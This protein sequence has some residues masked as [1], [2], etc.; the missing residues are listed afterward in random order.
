MIEQGKKLG[1]LDKDAVV[2]KVNP[3]TYKKA[4]GASIEKKYA[5]AGF[6]IANPDK[7]TLPNLDVAV[8]SGTLKTRIKETGQEGLIGIVYRNGKQEA[9]EIISPEL[10]EAFV[11]FGSR[12]PNAFDGAGTNPG[13]FFFKALNWTSRFSSRAITY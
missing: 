12:T 8:F 4:I 1:Q 9:Y 10:Q 7:K 6:K 5:E 3:I 13:R 11:S 2:R